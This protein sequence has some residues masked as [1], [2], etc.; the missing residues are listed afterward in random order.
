MMRSS[1]NVKAARL[2]WHCGNTTDLVHHKAKLITL[3]SVG[4]CTL[5]ASFMPILSTEAT[6]LSCQQRQLRQQAL[7]R[8]D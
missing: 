2:T 3:G 6:T 1:C 8:P 7:H 5:C 4:R